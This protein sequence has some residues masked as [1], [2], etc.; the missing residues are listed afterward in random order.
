MLHGTLHNKGMNPYE[1][2]VIESFGASRGGAY[3]QLLARV[4]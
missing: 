3:D 1:C 4:P 2:V